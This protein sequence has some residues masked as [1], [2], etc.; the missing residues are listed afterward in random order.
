[1][2]PPPSTK[3]RWRCSWAAGL[4]SAPLTAVAF[5]ADGSLVAAAAAPAAAPGAPL[6][7]A[8]GLWRVDSGERVAVLAPPSSSSSGAAA[9][10]LAAAAPAAPAVS[11]LSFVPGTAMLVAALSGGGHSSSSLVAW[12]LLTKA[13][14]WAAPL[15]GQAATRLSA[16]PVGGVVAVALAPARSPSSASSAPSSA[17]SPRGGRVLALRASDGAALRGWDL[18]RAPADALLFEQRGRVCGDGGGNVGGVFCP[19]LL[20]L[21]TDREFAVLDASSGVADSAAAAAAAAAASASAALSPP[22]KKRARRDDAAALLSSGPPS[23]FEAKFGGADPA[24]R[25]PATPERGGSAGLGAAG[26][27]AAASA[28]APWAALFDAPSHALPAPGAL[29]SKFLDS[30][31]LLPAQR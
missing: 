30:L 27:A 17:P 14:A 13:A 4:R 19:P 3:D 31:L 16:S 9:S 1:M 11:C 22:L 25:P 10:A 15:G 26:A 2:P 7:A 29:A 24:A 28:A 23:A 21:T 18:P 5:S 8:V 6:A 12:D 20:V